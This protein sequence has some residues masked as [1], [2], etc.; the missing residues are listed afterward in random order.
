M[1]FRQALKLYVNYVE[2]GFWGQVGLILFASELLSGTDGPT[3]RREVSM[4]HT[5]STL[6]FDNYKTISIDSVS[7]QA[8]FETF[9]GTENEC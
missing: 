3:Y 9:M 5:T 8:I 1:I 2:G 4:M 7:A 6:D